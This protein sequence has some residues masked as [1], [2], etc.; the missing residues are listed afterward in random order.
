M[1]RI[2]DA[3]LTPTETRSQFK[4][5]TKKSQIQTLSY[6]FCQA[7][8]RS[9]SLARS[10]FNRSRFIRRHF[11]EGVFRKARRI[12]RI[13]AR[14]NYLDVDAERPLNTVKSEYESDSPIPDLFPVICKLSREQVKGSAPGPKERRTLPR[15]R[16]VPNTLLVRD[17]NPISAFTA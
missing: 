3:K 13:Q 12:R 15:Q 6:F 7:T 11:L 8:S 4:Q 17:T 2:N 1:Q 16:S 10:I 5:R 9:V 14:E